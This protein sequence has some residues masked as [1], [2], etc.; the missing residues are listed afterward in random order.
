MIERTF[1][2]EKKSKMSL[3]EWL[4]NLCGYKIWPETH[5]DPRIKGPP[6]HIL[7]SEQVKEFEKIQQM[8]VDDGIT[9]KKGIKDD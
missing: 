4:L 9:Q 8:A 7:T 1:P 5:N 3:F 6:P 2:G